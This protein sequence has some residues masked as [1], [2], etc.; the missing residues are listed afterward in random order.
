MRFD[1]KTSLHLSDLTQSEQILDKAGMQFQG[2]EQQLLAIFEEA[3]IGIHRFTPGGRSIRANRAM[4]K[5]LGYSDREMHG[6]MFMDWTHPDDVGPTIK[7]V[8]RLHTG[9]SDN[10]S[11]EKRYVKKD[12]GTVWVYV[13]V[14][15]MRDRQGAVGQIIAFAEDITSR[16]RAINVLENRERDL[17]EKSARLEELNVALKVLLDQREREKKSIEERFSDSISGLILPCLERIRQTDPDELQMEY[18]NILESNLREIVRPYNHRVSEKLT[19]LSPSEARIANFIRQGYSSK[20]IASRLNI[21]SRT[22][23]FHRDNIRKKLELKNRK[24]N[25]QTYL[26]GL[27]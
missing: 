20:E 23:E 1:E 14:I 3:P 13:T 26:A 25:L 10:G 6:R 4:R 5:I 16:K 18:L 19:R 21:S 2:R 17:L 12:G 9:S 24:V 27:P 7:L 11:I 15:A 8:H 22:V